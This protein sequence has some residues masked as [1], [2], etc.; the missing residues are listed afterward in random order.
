MAPEQAAFNAIDVDTRADIY[1]LGVMLYELLT[2]STPIEREQLRKAALDEILRVVRESEPPAPSKRLSAT[3]S[4]PSIAAN[5]Q[6]EPQKLGRL[7]K[8][9]LDWIV[10]KALAKER[11]RRYETA[12]GFAK[13]VDRF[14]NHEPVSAGPPTLRYKLRKFVV[15]HRVHVIA[16]SLV[17]FALL[18]GMAG[19]TFGLIR[20]ERAR[21]EEAMQRSIAVAAK[22][23]AEDA[24]A[25]TLADYRASTDDAI[26]QLIGSKPELGPH[27]RAYIERTLKRWQTY[28][29]RQGD[30]ERSQAIRAEGHGR[31]GNL[32]SRLG[33]P[34]EARLEYERAIGVRKRLVAEHPDVVAYKAALASMRNN[35][36][37]VLSELGDLESAHGE[38][39]SARDLHQRIVEQHPSAPEHQ[40]HLA[41]A[42]FNLGRSFAARG[43]GNAAR[44]EYERALALRQRL[45]AQHPTN[46][47]YQLDLANAH[48]NLGSLLSSLKLLEAARPQLEQARDL[49]KKLVEQYP[50]APEYQHILAGA[51]YNLAKLYTDLGQQKL[52]DNEVKQAHEIM[53]KLARQYPAIPDYQYWLSLTHRALAK[54]YLDSGQRERAQSEVGQAIELLDT[55]RHDDSAAPKYQQEL[56]SCHI[57]LG[58]ILEAL[59]RREAAWA[60]FVKGRDLRKLLAETHAE[61]PA[62][63]A[64]LADTCNELGVRLDHLGDH[65]AARTEYEKALGLR[66]KLVAQHP[67]VAEYQVALGGS[68]CNTGR[69]VRLGGQP[70]EGRALFDKA[71]VTLTRVHRANPGDVMARLFLRNSY[72]AR[73]TAHVMLREYTEALKD[74]DRAIELS[75]E[76]EQPDL[77]ASRAI[78]RL[79]AGQVAAAVNEV[80]ELRKK[81]CGSPEHLYNFAC[82]YSVASGKFGDRKEEYAGKAI[83]LLRQAVNAGY[84]DAAHIKQDSDLDPLRDR[85][86]FQQFMKANDVSN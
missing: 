61:V 5:R 50:A 57:N 63:V 77:R 39:E 70:A 84:S 38:F 75:P 21:A 65:V 74:W 19:T 31:V 30:D 76:L 12:T 29:D 67:N 40:R 24:E 71:I 37:T 49:E 53:R 47:T 56:G 43:D 51:H 60:E 72:S 69:S 36:G 32:W 83:Q 42:Q 82:I 18:L 41:G 80:E 58:L 23:T 34:K 27:E 20:A 25:Q 9:E 16:A 68:Y 35:L 85:A 8:G 59:G 86:D 1:A 62:Y 33:R 28:S 26:E 4:T 44:T 55:L 73:A 64:E 81:P 7:L 3:G 17:L 6:M 14:L 45:A 2:G 54:Q 66:E 11:D 48:N 22:K 15:R 46:P 13:D 10:M 79:L 52:I 78:S